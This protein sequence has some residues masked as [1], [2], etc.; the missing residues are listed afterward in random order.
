[1]DPP[2]KPASAA[3]TSLFQ[4]YLRLRPHSST[5]APS[6]VPPT[7]SKGLYPILPQ[8]PERFLAVE[9][10]EQ[11]SEFNDTE[12]ANNSDRNGAASYTSM[13][14]HITI[15]PPSRGDAR[16]RAVEKFAF[17]RVFE[18]DKGQLELYNGVGVSGIVEGVLKEGRNGLLATLGVTGSG[19]VGKCSHQVELTDED[20]R[21]PFLARDHSAA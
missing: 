3:S 6:S 11:P 16:K 14:T 1:M 9:P 12:D 8:V 2:P 13:P 20:R 17:T 4:V 10:V 21:T 7:P 18:E 5:S 15:H 19:K